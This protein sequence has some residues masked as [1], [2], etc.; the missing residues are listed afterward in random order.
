MK[1]L[2]I[3]LFVIAI[4]FPSIAQFNETSTRVYLQDHSKKVSIGSTGGYDKLNMYGNVGFYQAGDKQITDQTYDGANFTIRAA[5]NY[6][7]YGSAGDLKLFG[8]D[9]DAGCSG[10][11][12]GGNVII[13]AGSGYS[14]GNVFITNGNFMVGGDPNFH[15]PVN[16]G[17]INGNLYVG[18]NNPYG[19]APSNGMWVEGR[20]IIGNSAVTG[21][22]ANAK[23]S[24]QGKVTAQEVVVTASSNWPDYVFSDKY[25]LK[26]ID[27][28]E[29]YIKENGH[30]PNVP[31]SQEVEENGI[32]SSE[33]FKIQMEKI[34][35]LSLY[36]IELKKRLIE[37]ETK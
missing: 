17:Q 18:S 11:T 24:V 30:L 13:G 25:D 8:G 36:I 26:S 9:G 2:L 37:L 4:A 5:A 10:G 35:E 28:L 19:L 14:H 22:H 15:Y 33:M 16:T 23:L 20:V 32:S 6:S 1:K 3:K 27:E 34:E 29:N 21:T 31:S 7:Y 12:D